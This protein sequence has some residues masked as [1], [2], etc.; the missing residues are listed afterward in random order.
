[1]TTP[2]GHGPRDHHA[3]ARTTPSCPQPD[4]GRGIGDR[5]ELSHAARQ[6]A[7][8]SGAIHELETTVRGCGSIDRTSLACDGDTNRNDPDASSEAGPR[9][10]LPDKVVLQPTVYTNLGSLMDVFA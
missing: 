7:M 1:M 6:L 2:S 10:R 4:L 5:V 9:T 8:I 3:P